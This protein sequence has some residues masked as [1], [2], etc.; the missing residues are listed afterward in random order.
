MSNR[1]PDTNIQSA[2]SVTVLENNAVIAALADEFDYIC[3]LHLSTDT[4]ER[5]FA[6]PWVQEMVDTID[7]KL[8]PHRRL[9]TL[10]HT[11]IYSEDIDLFPNKFDARTITSLLNENGKYE[12][13]F[14]IVFNNRLEWYRLKIARMTHSITQTDSEPTIVIGLMNINAEVEAN[15]RHQELQ[16][17]LSRQRR[18]EQ[19]LAVIASLSE[20]FEFLTFVMMRDDANAG[21]TI[22]YRVSPAIVSSIPGWIEETSM[23]RKLELIAEYLVVPEYRA[24]FLENSRRVNLLPILEKNKAHY[25]NFKGI[26]EGKEQYF[27]IKFVPYIVNKKLEGLVFGIRNVDSETRRQMEIEEE[28]SKALDMAETANRAKSAFLFNMSH[29]IRTPM[30][31][32][33][34]FTDMAFKNIGN[35]QE[36]IDCLDKVRSSSDF[37]LSLI[38]EILD[39]SRIESDKMRI[40]SKPCDLLAIMEDQSEIMRCSAEERGISFVNDFSG[41]RN[42]YVDMDELRVRQICTNLISNAIKYTGAGGK[43]SF[44]ITERLERKKGYGLY[45]FVISDNGIGMSEEFV[46]HIYEAFSR[47][48][49]PTINAIQGTGLGMSIVKKLVDL[50]EGEIKVESKLGEGTTVTVLL[51]FRFVPKSEVKNRPTKKKDFSQYDFRGLRVLLVEDNELNREIAIEILKSEGIRIECACNGREAIDIVRAHRST[52]FD[53]ILMDIQMPVMNGFDATKN[54]RKMRNYKNI[55]I[56]ALTANAFNEDRDK[57]LEAGMNDHIG[58]PIDVDQLKQTLSK[59]MKPKP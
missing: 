15:L 57:A 16:N 8:P 23:L 7:P 19:Q 45:K 12:T 52:F 46:K 26:M 11:L 56:I 5:H 1:V 39:M 22:D 29:D 48:D 24:H 33:I 59:Y 9:E 58:K 18:I 10:F 36:L 28:L 40:E 25:T 31:A 2:G 54:I 17:T 38:N 35:R 14:R 32:I 43:V 21:E 34:G 53:C 42:R 6:S 50:F 4:L 13:D 47:A 55:P 41:I 51:D 37:L 27:Q 30:N 20:D 3:F 49:D 44:T